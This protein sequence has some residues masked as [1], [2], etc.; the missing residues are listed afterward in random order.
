MVEAEQVPDTRPSNNLEAIRDAYSL[1]ILGLILYP[2]L[3]KPVS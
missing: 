3:F 2:S 1:I